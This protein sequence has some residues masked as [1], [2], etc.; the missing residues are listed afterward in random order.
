MKICQ[1]IK[2]IRK[3][4]NLSQAELAKN[5]G[6]EQKTISFWEVERSEPRIANLVTICNNFGVNPK[7]LLISE[8]EMFLSQ[9]DLK[10]NSNINISIDNWGSR[11]IKIQAVNN[12]CDK[13]FA[14]I[15]NISERRLIDLT[16]Y[17]KSPTFDEINAIKSNFNVDIDWL[18]YGDTCNNPKTNEGS[19]LLDLSPDKIIKLN[20]LLD[21]L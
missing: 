10:V 2:K 8:G 15:L 11:L 9:T 19:S 12:Y 21:N 13:E 20:K 17:S 3:E 6:V 5:I 4:L 7:W 18:L 1:K 16:L 14:K